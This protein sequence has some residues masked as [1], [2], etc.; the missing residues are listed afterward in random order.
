MAVVRLTGDGAVAA[1]TSMFVAHSGVAPDSIEHDRLAYGR[2][3]DSE[4]DETVDDGIV[5]LRPH[6]RG[7]HSVE[8]IVHGGP[9]V[10]E[11]MC[12][13]AQRAGAEFEVLVA[14]LPA[15]RPYPC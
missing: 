15:T 10:V 1:L 3:R 13:L 5:V 6:A 2:F 14:P 9:R 4:R 12:L 11:R 7:G 8:M